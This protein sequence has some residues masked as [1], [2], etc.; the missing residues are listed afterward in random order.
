MRRPPK[1]VKRIYGNL[2]YQAVSWDE[3]RRVIVKAEWHPGE[4][5]PRVGFVVTNLPMEPDWII[6]SYNLGVFLQGTDQPA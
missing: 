2:E 1:V 4:L 3:P 6:R 5:F